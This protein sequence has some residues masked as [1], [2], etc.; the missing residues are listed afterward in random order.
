M[1]TTVNILASFYYVGV[2]V[3]VGRSL[4]SSDKHGHVQSTF[5]GV[6]W[7]Q[8]VKMIVG[9]QLHKQRICD[10]FYNFVD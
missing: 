9:L 5:V 6:C 1:K 2:R 10:T 4:F 8:C 3:R 7:G